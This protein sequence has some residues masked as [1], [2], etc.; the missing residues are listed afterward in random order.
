MV[1]FDGY[2]ESSKLKG[3]ERFR[4]RTRWSVEPEDALVVASTACVEPP[5]FGRF[6][7]SAEV[8]EGDLEPGGP[9]AARQRVGAFLAGDGEV[10]LPGAVPGFVFDETVFAGSIHR[11]VA[12]AR[13][14]IR[15]EP[16]H[17]AICVR[18]RDGEFDVFLR[19]GVRV[20][21]RS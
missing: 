19:E 8:G 14:G 10:V 1:A 3:P 9:H 11:V 12:R 2:G 21:A 7:G 18:R 13:N 16:I 4:R 5:G 15:G 17:F 20:R 6:R